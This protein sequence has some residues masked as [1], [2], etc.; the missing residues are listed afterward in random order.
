MQGGVINSGIVVEEENN[1]NP[2]GLKKGAKTVTVDLELQV[3]TYSN[4]SLPRRPA[5]QARR[6]L[7]KIP[8]RLARK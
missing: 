8:T 1:P 7:L 4:I 3:A 2:K 5:S 6:W